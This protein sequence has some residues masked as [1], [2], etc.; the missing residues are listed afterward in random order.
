MKPAKTVYALA[1]EDMAFMRKNHGILYREPKELEAALERSGKKVY[2]VGD[3]TA[4]SLIGMPNVNLQAVF[5]DGMTRRGPI[6]PSMRETIEKWDVPETTTATRVRNPKSTITEELMEAAKSS[7][8]R[9][10]RVYVEGEEDLATVALF[11]V[12]KHGGIVAYGLPDENGTCVV[13]VTKDIRKEA[14]SLKGWKK[15]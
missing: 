12:L 11:A 4:H 14:L 3:W 6:P 9:R 15:K 7:E 10:S 1:E 13:E 2:A 5:Y 8:T